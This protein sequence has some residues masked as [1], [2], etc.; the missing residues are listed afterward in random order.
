MN[1]DSHGKRTLEQKFVHFDGGFELLSDVFHRIGIQGDELKFCLMEITQKLATQK[2]SA[3]CD[4]GNEQLF[5]H[6]YSQIDKKYR[7]L[8]LCLLNIINKIPWGIKIYAFFKRTA[9]KLL[10]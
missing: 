6:Y 9:S 4:Y 1:S 3:S 10:K 8:R 5:A 7:T 2:A